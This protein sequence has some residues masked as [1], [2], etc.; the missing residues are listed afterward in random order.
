M[1]AS[2]GLIP[3]D[4]NGDAYC[5]M[6]TLVVIA[7]SFGAAAGFTAGA[8]VIGIARAIGARR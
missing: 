3:A 7:A 4:R 6:R 1:T 8:A 5:G 2:A